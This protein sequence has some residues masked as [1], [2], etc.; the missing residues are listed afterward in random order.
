MIFFMYK[1]PQGLR[2]DY[3]RLAGA[4]SPVTLR[5]AVAVRR[6][7][8][9]PRRTCLLGIVSKVAVLQPAP[10]LT[11]LADSAKCEALDR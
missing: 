8:C 10:M 4:T 6:V 9:S 5:V 7:H 1:A 3:H 11:I 2:L